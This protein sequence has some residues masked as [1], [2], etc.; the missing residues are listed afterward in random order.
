MPTAKPNIDL[1]V[2]MPQYDLY[3][4]VQEGSLWIRGKRKLNHE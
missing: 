4:I 1:K 3:K 2:V